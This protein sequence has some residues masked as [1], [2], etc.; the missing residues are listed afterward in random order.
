LTTSSS[1]WRQTKR[2]DV[3]GSSAPGSSPPRTAPGSRCRC[4][5][6][7][8]RGGRSARPRHHRRESGRAPR[9]ADSR[10]REASRGTITASAPLEVV[11][12][13]QSRTAVADAR[14]GCERVALVARAG[15]LDHAESH[16]TIS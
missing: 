8:R 15:E 16:P 11:V 14:G 12:A 9:R 13:M 4:R 10:R 3:F 7:G 1:T 6:R 5:A 2:S